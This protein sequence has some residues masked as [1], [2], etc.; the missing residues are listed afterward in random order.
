MYALAPSLLIF[1][2]PVR[3]LV[4]S[5][6][7]NRGPETKKALAHFVLPSGFLQ[8]FLRALRGAVK[9]R[10]NSLKSI[11]CDAPPEVNYRVCQGLLF[12]RSNQIFLTFLTL[13]FMLYDCAIIV[14]KD[15]V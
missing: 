11:L 1:L 9:S 13:F 10:W 2:S 15:G 4:K 6:V 5:V 14:T 3:G 12:P 8:A 7:C